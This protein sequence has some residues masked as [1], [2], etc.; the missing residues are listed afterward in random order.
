MT[1][2]LLRARRLPSV[3][4]PLIRALVATLLVAPA[5]LTHPA[6]F[7]AGFHTA[8]ADA[9]AAPVNPTVAEHRARL[10]DA[11]SRLQLTTHLADEYDV[12]IDLADRI[13]RAALA[14]NVRPRVAFQLVRTESS[15]RR[16]A[17]SPVGAVGYTQVM[18]ATARW[19][20]PGTARGDLF[21]T[22]T[23]LRLGFRYLHYL[24]D[25]YDG[26]IWTALTAYNRGPGTVDRLR[27]RGEDADN[28]YA[29]RV[30]RN[31]A[32]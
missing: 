21:E 29:G 9:A 32:G 15:F 20:V 4:R 25:R 30:L 6:E 14:E 13:T 1:R 3:R 2:T 11:A 18:P 31:R 19:L 5:A 24:I 16:T 8:A 27:S 22:D 26:D 10:R 17:V 23:N 28:G 12:P 7:L